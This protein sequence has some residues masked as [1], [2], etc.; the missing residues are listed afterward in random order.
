MHD[1]RA[2][3]TEPSAGVMLKEIEIYRS[4]GILFIIMT[5]TLARTV[6]LLM[7]LEGQKYY[8]GV[9]IFVVAAYTFYKTILK[10]EKL[11]AP[12]LMAI[13]DIGYIDASVSVLSL[14]TAMFAPFAVDSRV[15]S[16]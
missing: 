3:K 15:L 14:Q 11:K 1:R 10:A 4:C 13:R 9:A 16:G 2:S 7:E 8:P 6:F 12:L 5:A